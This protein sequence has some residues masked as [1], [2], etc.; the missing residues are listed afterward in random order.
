ERVAVIG[1]GWI[2]S[3][4]A[5]SARQMGAEVVLIDPLAV[6]LQRVLGEEIGAMFARAHADHGVELRLGTAVAELRGATRV[7]QVVLGNG[8]VLRADTVVAGI[9]VVP[10]DDLAVSAGLKVDGGVVVDERL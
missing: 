7:E 3:E 8:D 4:V 5:A 1:A 9:G 10:R 2:G 6:P